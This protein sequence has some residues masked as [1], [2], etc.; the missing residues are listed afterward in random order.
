MKVSYRFPIH[1]IDRA[2]DFLSA[3][4]LGELAVAAEVVGFSAALP[5]P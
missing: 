4:A 1:R 2:E 3:Q 5:T